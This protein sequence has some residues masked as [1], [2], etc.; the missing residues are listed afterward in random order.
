MSERPES[1]ALPA[2]AALSPDDQLLLLMGLVAQTDVQ[3][4]N[5]LRAL[6]VFLR[7][8]GEVEPFKFDRLHAECLAMLNAMSLPYVW[9]EAGRDALADA[10][11]AHLE[12]NRVV[13]DAWVRK[14]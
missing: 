11:R 9:L 2:R 3:L 13:H 6:W 8:S 7:R 5:K 4:E 1:L 10:L 14:P 12:R